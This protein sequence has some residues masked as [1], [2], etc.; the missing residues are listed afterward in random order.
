MYIN[1]LSGNF[2]LSVAMGQIPGVSYVNAF[3]NA[4][5]GVQTTLTDIWARADATPTQQ[6]WL[7]PTAAR[8]HAIVSSSAADVAGG[9]GATSVVITGLTS[10]TAAEVTETVSLNGVTPVNTVNAYVMINKIIAKASATTTNVGV[11]VGTITATAATDTTISIVVLPSKGQSQLCV[12]GIPST[13][14]LYLENYHAS[15]HDITTGA[16]AKITTFLAVN[17]NP[18]I[19]TKAFATRHNLGCNT[20]GSATFDY[21][22]N[23]PMKIAGPAIVKMQA[24]GSAADLDVS[25][26]FDGF[27][28]TT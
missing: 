13:Q 7:A 12:Y 18:N 17:E 22:F 28:V 6:I 19:Q 15:L 26:G 4:P 9:T 23:I 14:S 20:V 16:G 5:D 2:N 21:A 8:I 11:N 3:G 25:A 27:L 1:T 24:I 10:W